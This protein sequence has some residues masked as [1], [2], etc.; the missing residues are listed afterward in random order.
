M[1][2]VPECDNAEPSKSP[3]R[4]KD[5]QNLFL[6]VYPSGH[7][8]WEYRYE[9]DGK[10]YAL[11]LGTYGARTAMGL[12]AAREKR[13][14]TSTKRAA[15]IDPVTAAK[16][17]S[18]NQRAA[19]EAARVARHK[20]QE[21]KARARLEAERGAITFRTIAEKWIASNKGS[22]SAGHAHQCEQSLNDHVYPKLGKK[23]PEAI[24]PAHVLDLISGMLAEGKVETAR[25]TRQRMDSAFSYAEAYYGLRANP[26]HTAR[27]Q[28]ASLFKA[29]RNAHPEEHY[30]A[31][32]VKDVP[33][34]LRAMRA[35]SG[36]PV[37]TAL[38]W[39]VTLTACRTGEA[40]G[41]KWQEFDLDAGLWT[42]PAQRMKSRREH[43]VYLAPVVVQLLKDLK[44]QTRGLPWVFPHPTRNDKPLSEN[45]LLY[46]LASIGF[47]DKQT[48]HGLRRVFSTIANASQM[49]SADVIEAALA[50]KDADSVRSAYNMAQYEKERR[51]L[52]DW[53]AG[54]LARLEAG[55][56]AKVVAIR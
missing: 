41:A 2:S 55:T 46:V 5:S 7:K 33:Q 4:L 38:L 19:L 37:T 39:F 29:A 40:R 21:A 50:H 56:A 47:K 13:D 18:E 49:F 54:E 6:V 22:W 45:A 32:A 23:H 15:G 30:P 17:E 10:S 16:L 8:S 42:I 3:Y 48:G 14:E 1:L 12:K 31:V 26:V 44:P 34:L 11:I 25:R 36:S 51:K 43:V 20:A 28:L 27:K 53:Y 52:A 35:Y 24:E 9:A